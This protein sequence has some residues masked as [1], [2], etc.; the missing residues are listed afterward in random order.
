MPRENIMLIDSN[1]LGWFLLIIDR[2]C[3]CCCA[4]TTIMMVPQG[5]LLI[6]NG[7]LMCTEKNP[8]TRCHAIAHIYIYEVK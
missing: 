2:C 7:S 5:F 8:H 3:C 6:R 1:K 4:V